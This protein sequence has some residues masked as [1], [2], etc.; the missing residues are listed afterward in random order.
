MTDAMRLVKNLFKLGLVAL[1][2]II[3]YLN[4]DTRYSILREFVSP[5][6]KEKSDAMQRGDEKLYVNTQIEKS[7][8]I[9]GSKDISKRDGT[10]MKVE[11]SQMFD[12]HSRR[13]SVTMESDASPYIG[14]GDN[15]RTFSLNEKLLVNNGRA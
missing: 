8:A 14:H 9:G 7:D 1:Q 15:V 3:V 4:L 5:T 12:M 13:E 11:Q 2:Y 6:Q 10:Q